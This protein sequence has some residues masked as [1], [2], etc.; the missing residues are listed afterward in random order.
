MG[1]AAFVRRGAVLALA[2]LLLLPAIAATADES[3][4]QLEL[5]IEGLIVPQR[6]YFID[7]DVISFDV[8]LSNPGSSTVSTDTNPD[9]PASFQIMQSE[10][11]FDSFIEEGCRNQTRTI[12]INAGESL[13]LDSF[14][15]ALEN[16]EFGIFSVVGTAQSSGHSSSIDFTSQ[17]QIDLFSNFSLEVI[18]AQTPSGDDIN[19]ELETVEAIVHL[20]NLQN[21]T[22]QMD[23]DDDCRYQVVVGNE[24][25]TLSDLPC[26][27]G[28]SFIPAFGVVEIGWLSLD[29]FSDGQ[30]TLQV[31]L[32]AQE[33]F[34]ASTLFTWVNNNQSTIT[35]LDASISLNNGQ[36]YTFGDSFIM[37][38]SIDNPSASN[39]QLTFPSTCRAEIFIINQEGVI[40]YDTRD[41]R[42]CPE[43][44]VNHV[45]EAG[46]SLQIQHSSWNFIDRDGCELQTGDYRLIVDVPDYM[47]RGYNSIT[48]FSSGQTSNCGVDNSSSSLDFISIEQVNESTIEIATA[49]TVRDVV[50]SQSCRLTVKLYDESFLLFEQVH[51]CD[52]PLGLRQLLSSDLIFE[53]I[54]IYMYDSQ[55][56][57][58]TEGTYRID[59][60][61]N[62][63][64]SAEASQYF[65]WPLGVI[66]EEGQ[67]SEEGEEG[68]EETETEEPIEGIV[69][70]GSWQFKTTED[71]VCWLFTDTLGR[72]A[73]IS[74]STAVG[75]QWQPSPELA[76]NYTVFYTGDAHHTCTDYA[77]FVLF[78]IKDEYTV[79]RST[80]S[81][82]IKEETPES[83]IITEYGEPILTSV[84]AVSFSAILL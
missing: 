84:V 36:N 39:V 73:V 27:G 38:A 16:L 61:T 29:G 7:G 35:D 82:S 31:S 22:I 1:A 52:A 83:G 68:N 28:H 49:F 50:W 41:I 44:E 13:V 19:D 40:V 20:V 62:T 11:T 74:D 76:G 67:E 63:W 81:T 33:D 57:I 79:F 55:M 25:N 26:S 70:H 77:A 65:E 51:L 43:M 23:I 4:S 72:E 8:V 75:I 6:G 45:I 18:V 10:V 66:V 48:Y 56:E 24:L 80:E 12:E 53:D 3:E 60:I 32:P 78:E 9:C 42:D 37:T 2:F 64:P 30:H 69:V 59:I 15:Y 5:S 34:S 21:T 46:N 71:G 47:V 17:A 58:L 54:D 14:E